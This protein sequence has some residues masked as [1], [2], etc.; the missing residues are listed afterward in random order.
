MFIILWLNSNIHEYQKSN[1]I[2][3]F[4]EDKMLFHGDG[5]NRGI[6]YSLN[7]AIEFSLNKHMTHI[8]TMD[9]DSYFEKQ[10]LRKFKRHILS[11]VKND[12]GVF[13]SNPKTH[14]GTLFE[15]DSGI[16]IVND[17]ITSGSILPINIFEKTGLFKEELFI[18]AVDYEFCYRIKKNYGLSTIVFTDIILEHSIGYP[19][20]TKLGYNVDEY[21]A[22]RTY[23]I[24]RNHL[25]VYWKYKKYYDH[26]YFTDRIVFRLIKV[27]LNEAHK[28]EKVSAIIRGLVDGV[29]LINKDRIN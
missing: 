26:N 19:R 13:G 27:T 12:I 18:D 10:G 3:E 7:R 5:T 25:Y 4:G 11:N 20:R 23:H 9:Q 21:S 8:L 22:F 6:G 1:I 28:L 2:E 16:R 17:T 14:G 29:K 24:V 15:I